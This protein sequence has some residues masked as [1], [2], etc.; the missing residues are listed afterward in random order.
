MLKF[1]E[2]VLKKDDKALLDAHAKDYF[3]NLLPQLYDVWMDREV[4][5][6]LGIDNLMKDVKYVPMGQEI[7]MVS[8]DINVDLTREELID[9]IIAVDR[10]LHKYKP[11]QETIKLFIKKHIKE[12]PEIQ[13]EFDKYMTNKWHYE[14]EFRYH[15]DLYLLDV[16]KDLYNRQ[17]GLTDENELKIR[18]NMEAKTMDGLKE[19]LVNI[20]NLLIRY[21]DIVA[22]TMAVTTYTHLTLA[23]GEAALKALAEKQKKRKVIN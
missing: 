8:F 6:R 5:S 23:N 14:H 10:M 2:K 22:K 18:S 4:L 19:S 17:P 3:D 15:G 12:H 7:P 11:T 20:L 16:F 9:C 21:H 1:V 13:A